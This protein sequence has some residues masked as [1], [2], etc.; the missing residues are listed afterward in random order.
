VLDCLHTLGS[1]TKL[2]TYLQSCTCL[3]SS[4]HIASIWRSTL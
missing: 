1:D 2:K 3:K 4:Q